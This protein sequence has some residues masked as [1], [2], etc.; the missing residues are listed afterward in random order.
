MRATKLQELEEMA[1]KAT[2]LDA[3]ETAAGLEA[4]G[5]TEVTIMGEDGRI[6]TPSEFALT[7]S[8]DS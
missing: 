8:E 1:A 6:Y 4:Q 2:R 7:L 3:F 5:I